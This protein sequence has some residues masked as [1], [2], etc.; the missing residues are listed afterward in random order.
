[1]RL[2]LSY[3]KRIISEEISRV[4]E[5]SDAEREEHEE[6]HYGSMPSLSAIAD[7]SDVLLDDENVV[8]DDKESFM[9]PPETQKK[10]RHYF[11]KMGLDGHL[12]KQARFK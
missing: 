2:R 1:M 9:V 12:P 6:A 10:L 5:A 8:K 7:D 4:S 3:L 11:Q